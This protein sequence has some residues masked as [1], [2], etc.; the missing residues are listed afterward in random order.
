MVIA[1]DIKMLPL[2]AWYFVDPKMPRIK[3]TKG[4]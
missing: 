1:R 3:E 2:P 4:L